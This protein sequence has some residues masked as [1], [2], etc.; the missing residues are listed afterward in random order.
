MFIVDKDGTYK[1]MLCM[2]CCLAAFYD[3]WPQCP[4]EWDIACEFL[5]HCDGVTI[6]LSSLPPGDRLTMGWE[7][8]T[9][10][11]EI[12]AGNIACDG[13]ESTLV[14]LIPCTGW[15]HTYNPNV[16]CVVQ[17]GTY[18]SNDKIV[19]YGGGVPVTY[20]GKHAPQ[21]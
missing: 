4:K 12:E 14:D 7:G 2:G 15:D 16:P 5:C 6:P 3:E 8:P 11:W 20:C 9:D 1:L 19:V 13:C 17:N 21:G 18:H 10:E